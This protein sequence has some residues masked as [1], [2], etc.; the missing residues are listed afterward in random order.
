MTTVAIVTPSIGAETLGKT[1]ESIRNQTYADIVH[2]IFVDG[3][4]NLSKVESILEKFDTTKYTTV[5]VIGENIGKGWYG[6][7]VYAACSFLVNQDCIIYLD[8]D[9]WLDSD[10]VETM[11]ER[12]EEGNDWA[13]SLR[14]IYKRDGTFFCNDNCES[15][16][17]W[18]TYF[19][20][21]V[22][23]IDTSS[24]IVRREVAVSVGHS[25]YGQWGAD[26]QFFAAL[27]NYFPNFACSNK[28]T[29]CYRLGGN[30]GSVTEQF[31]INGNKMQ[32]EKYGSEEEYPWLKKEYT[33]GP[34]ISIK[35]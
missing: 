33:I 15:L 8:E 23:H 10:H 14:K 11:V 1:I 6:H 7:R 2:H 18:P 5:N 13:Y 24:F 17:K 26:R 27:S 30:E 31:F 22:R 34:G 19:D 4:Q 28:H 35:M 20:E 32:L 16:G 29:L 3:K 21:N 25:W 9:N 12:I